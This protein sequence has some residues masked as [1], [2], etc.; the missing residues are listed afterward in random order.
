MSSEH[1]K[2]DLKD[3]YTLYDENSSE[4]FCDVSAIDNDNQGL[5][6]KEKEINRILTKEEER[7]E[8]TKTN[9]IDHRRKII[10]CITEI[11]QKTLL[12]LEN[13]FKTCQKIIQEGKED[14]Q[15]KRDK[16]LHQKQKI[17]DV[18]DSHLFEDTLNCVPQSIALI[19][20][21][22]NTSDIVLPDLE[23]KPNNVS[24]DVLRSMFGTFKDNETCQRIL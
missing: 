16:V 11:E 7:F 18:L 21:Y 8:K 10:N 17:N 14:I 4:L 2:H 5:I 1:Q 12:D 24:T 15:A 20:S 3:F 6:S 9:I 19:K 13:N 22:R 23:F